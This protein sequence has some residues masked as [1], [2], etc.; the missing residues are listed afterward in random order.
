LPAHSHSFSRTVRWRR[1][2]MRFPVLRRVPAPLKAMLRPIWAAID[3]DAYSGAQRA[4]GSFASQTEFAALAADEPSYR[5]RDTYVG[6]AVWLAADLIGR[7]GLTTALELG[8]N[9]RPLISG[10]DVM[11]RVARPGLASSGTVLVY[12]AT[13]TPWPMADKQYDLFVA[14]Q[15]F[16]HLASDQPA[17]FREVRR[18]ARN[19]IISLPIDWEMDN[20]NPHHGISHAEALSWFAPVRPTRVIIGNPGYRQRLLYACENLPEEFSGTSHLPPGGWRSL[21]HPPRAHGSMRS[22]RDRTDS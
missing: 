6:A 2:G 11:D 16:E 19:A 22:F 9:T 5:G 17:V 3:R 18:V 12:D 13:D 15:V 14:L 20:R 7:Y 21:P 4:R 8:P 10:A 1:P